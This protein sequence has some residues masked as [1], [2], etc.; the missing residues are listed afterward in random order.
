[1]QLVGAHIMFNLK[2]SK[3]EES[4][5]QEQEGSTFSGKVSL[6]F[7]FPVGLAELTKLMKQYALPLFLGFML[8]VFPSGTWLNILDLIINSHQMEKCVVLHIHAKT[9]KICQFHENGNPGE[10]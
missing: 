7:V 9:L 8:G 3:Q 5:K 1:M 10:T 6:T 2:R 4:A